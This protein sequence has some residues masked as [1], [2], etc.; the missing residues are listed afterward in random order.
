MKRIHRSRQDCGRHFTPRAFGSRRRSFDALQ[1]CKVITL[2]SRR[3]STASTSRPPPRAAFP[4]TNIPDTFIEEV[5]DH[6]MMLLLSGFRRLIEQDKLVRQGRWSE[7]RPA[8]LKISAA[9]GADAGL[10]LGSGGGAR[11]GETRPPRS[12]YD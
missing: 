9:D 8:L 1:N 11:G 5:A 12:G 4:V 7:G 2:G 10:H 3:A 6:A